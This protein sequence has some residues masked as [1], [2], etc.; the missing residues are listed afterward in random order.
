MCVGTGPSLHR[1]QLDVARLRGWP[2]Y[3]CNDAFRL[4]PDAALLTACNWQWWDRRWPEV[5]GL[6]CEKWTTR[7]ESAER[8]GLRWIAERPCNGSGLS[9]DPAFLYHG[10]GSGFQ[11]LGLAW[12]ARPDRIVLLGYDMTYAPDYDGRARRAGS[13]P[14]HFFGEYE[15]ELQHWPSVRIDRGR[16]VELLGFYA[17]VARQRPCEIVNCSGGALDCFPRKDIADV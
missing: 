15:P 10:H 3:V 14:R 11:L 16:H 8:Y 4:A 6:P 5:R 17:D 2:I 13:S 12:R 9:S 7:R 1:A